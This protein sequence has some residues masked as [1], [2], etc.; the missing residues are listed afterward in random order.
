[1]EVTSFVIGKPLGGICDPS[2][3][4]TIDDVIS[5]MISASEED[6]QSGSK[7]YPSL[8]CPARLRHLTW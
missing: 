5:E 8:F 3:S 1:M 4:T 6:A 7:P 2:S